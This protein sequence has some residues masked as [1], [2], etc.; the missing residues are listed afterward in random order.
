MNIVVMS[1]I[2]TIDYFCKAYQYYRMSIDYLVISFAVFTFSN[3][4]V[5]SRS[6][7]ETRK[8]QKQFMLEIS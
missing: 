8:L 4:Y 7:R 2:D 5:I 6:K 3:P 1:S